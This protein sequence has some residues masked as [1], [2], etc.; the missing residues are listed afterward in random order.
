MVAID[1]VEDKLPK[2]FGAG[3][4]DYMVLAPIVMGACHAAR[5]MSA[6]KQCI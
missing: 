3:L 2:L 6:G 4:S 5:Y 1:S